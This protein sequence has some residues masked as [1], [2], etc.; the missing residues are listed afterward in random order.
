MKYIVIYQREGRL[1]NM[2][3]W[4]D[5]KIEAEKGV[6]SYKVCLTGCGR[7]IIS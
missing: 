2:D 5:K 1:P 3:Q 6:R 4:F 7:G